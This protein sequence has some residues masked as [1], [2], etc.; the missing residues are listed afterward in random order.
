MK[1]V[2]IIVCLFICLFAGSANANL[3]TNG[4]FSTGDL[5]GWTVTGGDVTS[6]SEF[7]FRAYDNSG[8]GIL[9]QDIVTTSGLL[10]DISFDTFASQIVGNDFA[11]V[12][13]GGAL[14]SITTT[15]SWVTN[16]G[17]FT[18]TSGITNVAFYSATDSGTGTWRMDNVS[19]DTSAVPEPS[20]IALMGLG[21]LGFVATRRKIKK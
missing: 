4:D 14:N 8:W 13:D 15:T 10:Y 5:S 11:W 2:K 3:I 6:A 9:S 18:A 1:N 21:L 17:T 7:L 16:T 19:V 12:I 20:A